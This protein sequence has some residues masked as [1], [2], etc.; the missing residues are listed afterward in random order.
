MQSLHPD[1]DEVKSPSP[2]RKA[3]V[4]LALATLVSGVGGYLLYM[5]QGMLDHNLRQQRSALDD[6]RARY[7]RALEEVEIAAQY[8]ERYK[9]FEQRGVVGTVDQLGLSDH[10]R[11][12]VPELLLSDM[13]VGFSAAQTLPAA[14]R[15]QLDATASIYKHVEAK[16][17]F[18]AQHSADLL[19]VLDGIERRNGSRFLVKECELAYQPPPIDPVTG[20]GEPTVRD[21]GNMTTNCTA[22]LMEIEPRERVR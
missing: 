5:W 19:T 21:K 3:L 18:K 14:V 10:L 17:S 2:Y 11:Q 20:R 9:A 4:T 16:I 22:W 6:A 1:T 12:Q 7:N 8:L 13:Q 15:S